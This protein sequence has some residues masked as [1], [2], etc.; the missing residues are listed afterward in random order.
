MMNMPITDNIADILHITGAITAA[1]LVQFLLPQP[2]L[3]AICK[4]DL[5]DEAG[6]FFA[7][8]WGLLAFVM[9]GL[10]MYAGDHAELR[11]A[12]M[13]AA[14]IEKAGFAFFVFR[15]FKRIHMRGLRIAAVFDTA[16]VLMYGAYLLEWA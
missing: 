14:S 2:F 8:H 16:C 7:R 12:V 3:R 10:L 13:L 5:E 9:G 15:D 6:L 4:I 11:F 1:M